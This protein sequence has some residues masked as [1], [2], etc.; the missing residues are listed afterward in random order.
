MILRLILVTIKGD[1]PVTAN[2][3]TL[4]DLMRQRIEHPNER[5][6]LFTTKNL[7]TL[8]DYIDEL[9]DTVSDLESELSNQDYDD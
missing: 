6:P 5:S 1:I 9:K 7:T 8:L 3:E 4:L 2:I